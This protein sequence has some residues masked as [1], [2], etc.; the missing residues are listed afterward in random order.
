MKRSP[1]PPRKAP[2]PR[3]GPRARRDAPEPDAAERAAQAAYDAARGEVSRR[4]GGR[5]RCAELARTLPPGA[6]PW[7]PGCRGR[8]DPHHIWK[9]RRDGRGGPK[10]DAA[11]MITL[12]RAH[13]DWVH[14]ARN[15]AVAVE[16]GLLKEAA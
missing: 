11:N 16:L 6:V 10:A 7:P 2:M 8:R 14:T 3:S 15:K 9:T 1:M 12:C 13:H 5:C 4:D